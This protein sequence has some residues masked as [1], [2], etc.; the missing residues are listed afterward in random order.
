[1]EYLIK[2]I[3]NFSVVGGTCDKI[4]NMGIYIE[5]TT[6][7]K[8]YNIP[9]CHV[10]NK[11][12]SDKRYSVCGKHVNKSY[13]TGKSLNKGK[14]WKLNLNEEQKKRRI[15]IGHTRIMSL[16][17][18]EKIRA[19]HIA[20]PNKKFRNTSIEL[21]IQDELA[22]R[23]I[24]FVKQ[25]SVIGVAIVDFIL[26]ELNVIIQCDGCYWHNCPEHYPNHHKEQ[27]IK[28]LNKDAKLK[29]RGFKVYRFWEHDINRSAKECVDLIE[30]IY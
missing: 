30:E 28:D 11:Q 25:F 1:M 16:E 10:C 3:V 5:K 29:S 21:S 7:Y 6:G 13:C 24:L 17:S 4:M 8:R 9:T 22:E 19:W 23:Q 15:E 26:P 2:V 14:H 20:N 12:L 27:R 18:R